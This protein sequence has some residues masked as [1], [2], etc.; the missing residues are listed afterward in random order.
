M[1]PTCYLAILS[2]CFYFIQQVSSDENLVNL[3]LTKEDGNLMNLTL[4]DEEAEEVLSVLED[5][6]E[7]NKTSGDY[8]NENYGAGRMM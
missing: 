7:T 5:K 4:T 2:V 1:F 6:L 3:T 8:H